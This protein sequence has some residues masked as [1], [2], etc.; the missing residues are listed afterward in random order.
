MKIKV[1][2]DAVSDLFVMSVFQ[3]GTA[4]NQTIKTAKPL[5]IRQ[6]GKKDAGTGEYECMGGAVSKRV[7]RK[8]PA[9]CTEYTATFKWNCHKQTGRNHMSNQY[10]ISY[11]LPGRGVGGVHKESVD[12]ASE[13]DARAIVRAK[14][15]NLDVRIVGGHM[16]NF[17]GGDDR[18]DRR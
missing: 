6:I 9:T 3:A 11:E 18:N 8:S 2:L 1:H 15:G 14:F 5:R 13:S 7:T 17:G 16:T 12:A 4:R 10:E